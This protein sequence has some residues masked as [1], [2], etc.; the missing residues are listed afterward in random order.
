MAFDDRETF[1]SLQ[2]EQKEAIGILSIGTF[3]EY[4][5]LLLYV[6]MAVL[7]NELFFPKTDPHTAKLL[8]ALAFCSTFVLRPFGALL[9]GWIGDNIGRK[10]TVV[11]TTSMMALS[12]ITMY[13]LPTYAQIGATA[14][15]GMTICRML[16]GLS[17]MG[18]IIG[19]EL[20]LTEIIKRPAVFPVVGFLTISLSLGGT[21]ALGIASLVTSHEFDWRNAFLIGAAIALV[22]VFAR[23]RLRETTDFVDAKRRCKRLFEDINV[24][25]KTLENDYVYNKNI[26]KVTPIAY[27]FLESPAPVSF[28]IM[29]VFCGN[30]LKKNFGYTIEQVI[31]QNLL[32]SALEVISTIILVWLSYK[33]YPLKI[34]KVKLM[35]YFPFVII[36][37]YLLQNIHS[38]LVV[39]CAQ[40]YITIFGIGV[41]TASPIFYKSFPVF[42]RFTFTAF[43]Y[44]ISRISMHLLTSF[45]LVYLTKYFGY[46]GLWFIMIP[47]MIGYTWGLQHFINLEKKAR[48]YPGYEDIPIETLDVRS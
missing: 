4:F 30:I 21:A 6:H 48:N 42:K 12:C 3:L 31:H 39:L 7:L 19:A 14:A 27:F 15:W 22:G 45:G 40:F 38:E 25:E 18:E 9:F 34:L 23:T 33:I 10:A 36:C 37:P 28:Y 1:S 35:L 5:D 41:L 17:S 32:N 29:Y 24:K 2:R 8:A 46:Y 20:Y 26:S 11:I 16:Q 43:M 44:A 47:V 13:S